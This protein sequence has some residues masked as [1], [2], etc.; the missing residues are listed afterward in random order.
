MSSFPILSVMLAV[1]LIAALVCLVVDA[2]VARTLALVATLIDFVLGVLLWLNFDV[3][4]AQWQFQES[5]Q[6][7]AGFD[8]KLGIDGIAL[9]LIE[10]SVFLSGFEKFK[11]FIEVVTQGHDERLAARVRWKHYA[12]SGYLPQKHDVAAQGGGI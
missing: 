7:F 8:W 4:G 1:P 6:L 10:L 3:G 5:K 2:K 11:R 9:V 12:D